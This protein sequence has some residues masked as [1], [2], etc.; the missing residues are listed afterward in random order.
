[1]VAR[2]SRV[3]RHQGAARVTVGEET[4]GPVLMHQRYS[5]ADADHLDRPDAHL[6]VTD[7]ECPV[8]DDIP[9]QTARPAALG[10][11]AAPAPSIPR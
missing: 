3:D 6:V 1:M 8:P 10:K 4:H 11:R 5:F 2:R 9:W 7:R